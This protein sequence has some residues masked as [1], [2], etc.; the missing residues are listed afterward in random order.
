MALVRSNGIDLDVEVHG[1]PAGTPLLLVMGLGMPA[2]LWPDPL[3]ETLTG[4][5][6]RVLTFDNRDAGG[7]T[8]LEGVR[9]PNVLRA[10]ARA[11]RRRPVTAPYT[12]D[13]MVAD[14]V[15]L[16]DALG[17]DQVHVVGASMGGMISQL[18]AAR[19]TARVL[20]LT[21]IMSNSGNPDRRMAFGSWK[22]LRAIIRPPP[23]PDD[24]EAVVRHLVGL[25][26]VIGSPA[27]LHEIDLARPYFE[28][29]AR[30][31]LYRQ[32]T[33]RQMLAILATGDRRSL[34]REIHAPTMVLHGAD[35][36]LVPLAAGIDSAANIPGS[37]LEVVPGMGHDFPPSLMATLAA[38]IAQHCRAAQPATTA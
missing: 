32:G 6:F 11:L 37:R 5:G 18:I 4:A 14:T 21:S 24:H 3:I 29:A 28:R 38:R 23:P 8:R 30:R 25:F 1:D 34:L 17:I 20:S 7:S 22:A 9:A 12:L 13:D 31:G 26:S 35:D 36:P 15:G 19:H 10:I 16:L 33:M 2:A 27:Y